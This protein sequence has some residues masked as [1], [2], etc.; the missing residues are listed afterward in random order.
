MVNNYTDN[1][2]GLIVEAEQYSGFSG[3]VYYRGA[4]IYVNDTDWLIVYP[5]GKVTA[6]I[7][8]VFQS[9]FTLSG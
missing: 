8:G 2:T 7:D 4:I 3:S 9:R 1:Q 6:S 5:S